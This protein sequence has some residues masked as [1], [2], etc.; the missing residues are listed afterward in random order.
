[1]TQSKVPGP[2]LGTVSQGA[3]GGS[4]WPVSISS[5][6]TISEK[7]DQP[8]S[9]TATWTSATALNT[10]VTVATTGYG[11]ANVSIQV[12]STVTAGVIT[13][14][15]S[16][17]GGTVYYPAGAVRIDNG[18]QENVIALAL[19]PGIANNRMWAASVDAMTQIRARLSTVVAGA[20]NV[21]VRVGVVGSGIEPFVA[22]RSRKVPTYRA[23]Y[24]L[25]A[26]SYQLSNTFA[27]GSRKQYATI[28]HAAAATRT[29]RLRKVLVAITNNTVASQGTIDLVRITTAPATG[30]P[31]ITPALPDSGDA[32]AEATCLALPT[33]AG[34]E[35]AA[36]YSSTYFNYGVTGASSTTQPPPAI[37]WV[38]LI[39]MSAHGYDDEAKLPTIRAGVLEGWAVT[40][41]SSGAS[42]IA[43]MV[44][45]EFT[46]ETP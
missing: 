38:D 43:G 31:A 39:A 22:T 3:A 13:L 32:A 2:N 45:I 33:T 34:T 6:P 23:M 8:A 12:P 30:N 40:I 46:E 7:Q 5:V 29:V 9:T 44:I 14:E 26:R 27:A 17:D 1:M 24:R 4:P 35:S 25:A 20:G 42:A 16:D 10:A 15:V 21:V 19:S 41:D 36:F 37:P 11:T 28:H 18:V